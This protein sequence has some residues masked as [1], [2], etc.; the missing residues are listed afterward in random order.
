MRS[1]VETDPPCP[2]TMT[3]AA[4]PA[5]QKAPELFNAFEHEWLF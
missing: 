1:Q 5:L 2:I 4:I 3:C